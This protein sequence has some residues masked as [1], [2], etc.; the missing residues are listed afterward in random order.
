MKLIEIGFNERFTKM[1][2]KKHP[3]KIATSRYTQKAK[4]DDEF[5]V[6][7]NR[8]KID[9]VVKLPLWFIAMKLA[10]TEGCRLGQVE[11]IKIWD[12]CYPKRKFQPYTEVFY[13]VFHKIK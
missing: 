2:M 11:F 9:F 1:L 3:K 12:E 7:K 8:F 4:K 5:I 13:H 10:K 6:G